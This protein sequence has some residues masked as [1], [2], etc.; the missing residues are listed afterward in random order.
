MA[1]RQVSDSGNEHPLLTIDE[2]AVML[3]I[4]R[5]LAYVLARQYRSS[6]GRDGLPNLL[7]GSCIRV[8]RWAADILRTTGR[9]VQLHDGIAR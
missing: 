1:A 2:A 7:F 8:P 3:R 5:S 9:V 6:D 4:S